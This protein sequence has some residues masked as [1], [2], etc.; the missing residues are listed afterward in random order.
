MFKKDV[1]EPIDVGFHVLCGLSKPMG[2]GMGLLWL[3]S[4]AVP[5]CGRKSTGVCVCVSV[6]L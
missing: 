3:K 5:V 1:C 2:L 6:C 4:G